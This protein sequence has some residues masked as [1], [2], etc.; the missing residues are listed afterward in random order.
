MR[1]RIALVA[2]G[3]L[4]LSACA[5]TSTS[6]STR[7]VM[8]SGYVQSVNPLARTFVLEQTDPV[9]PL[10]VM[11]PSTTAVCT[12]TC[13]NG[14]MSIFQSQDTVTLSGR[15]DSAGRIGAAWVDVNPV[16][17]HSTVVTASPSQVTVRLTNSGGDIE[18]G[19]DLLQATPNM[20][21][22]GAD[23]FVS[24]FPPLHPGQRLYFT[25][26]YLNPRNPSV[27]QVTM[28]VAG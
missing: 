6:L 10:T 19:T 11:V 2:A 1:C 7:P 26:T 13:Q 24:T 18:Q 8:Y 27:V 21:D 15:T 17:S 5:G 28:F 3:G 22:M 25:G 23:S 9:H 16:A 14:N 12:T 4:A 20:K